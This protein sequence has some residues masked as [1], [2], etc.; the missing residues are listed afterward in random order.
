MPPPVTT[1]SSSFG[2]EELIY[3]RSIDGSF[4]WDILK[5]S[6]WML[7]HLLLSISQTNICYSLGVGVYVK[8][9][10]SVPAVEV[11]QRS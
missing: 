10:P 8:K 5:P 4:E 9:K 7:F 2:A 11:A 3:S 6:F 1:L